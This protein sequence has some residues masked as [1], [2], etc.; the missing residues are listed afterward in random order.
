MLV[1]ESQSPLQNSTGNFVGGGF[2]YRLR[3]PLRGW[4]NFR[5]STEIAVCL[6]NGMR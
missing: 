5:F 6:G 4:K 1:F 2:R 3:R